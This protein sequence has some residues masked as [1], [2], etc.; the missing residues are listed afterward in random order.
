ML[1]IYLEKFGIF[2][3]VNSLLIVSQLRWAQ[4]FDYDDIDL[5][6]TM[7]FILS[8]IIYYGIMKYLVSNH[9]NSDNISFALS[10]SILGIY[11]NS[12]QEILILLVFIVIIYFVK[13]SNSNS[14][15]K[16]FWGY[17]D[18][19]VHFELDKSNLCITKNNKK[20]INI[21]K[22]K[23]LFTEIVKCIISCKENNI[24]KIYLDSEESNKINNII[25]NIFE[26]FGIEASIDFK[27]ES[28]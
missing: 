27:Y 15:F 3:F 16:D 26:Y 10:F 4:K 23:Y 21:F 25:N 14:F 12:N 13:K 19:K 9:I 1:V 11:L 24:T 5:R 8:I 7:S 22:Y 2:L 6:I 28:E 17:E 20:E 18:Y